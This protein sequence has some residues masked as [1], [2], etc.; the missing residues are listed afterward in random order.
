M[1]L[2]PEEWKDAYGYTGLYLVSSHGRVF[3]CVRGRYIPQHKL[4]GYNLVWLSKDRKCKNVRVHR[5]VLLRFI[6]AHPKY[7]ICDHLDGVRD[8]NYIGNL[9]WTDAKGNVET[10]FRLGTFPLG[11]KRWN[12][13][14]TDIQVLHILRTVTKDKHGRFKG[15]TDLANKM[16]LHRSTIY[17][18]V[19]RKTWRHIPVEDNKEVIYDHR[20]T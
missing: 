4:K 18:I 20:D 12:S 6:G 8:N 17:G 16:G 2:Q 9:R 3:D 11:S 10:A 7:D 5:L 15:A 13:K 19:S 1:N 14:L